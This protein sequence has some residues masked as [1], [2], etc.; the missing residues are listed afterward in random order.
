MHW[1]TQSNGPTQFDVSDALFVLGAAH[2]G[3]NLP[4]STVN[5]PQIE[6]EHNKH[7]R[8]ADGARKKRTNRKKK[9]KTL[10]IIC[11][12]REQCENLSIC[13]TRTNVGEIRVLFI[14]SS[15]AL[16]WWLSW[17]RPFLLLLYRRAAW[18]FAFVV[19]FTFRALQFTRGSA[20]LG[21]TI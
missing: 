19:Q 1:C 8:K 7:N 15:V 21:A 3:D 12:R 10:K 4:N 5:A 13:T 18:C 17:S 2:N 14:I 11:L 20:S 16:I 9:K 6:E